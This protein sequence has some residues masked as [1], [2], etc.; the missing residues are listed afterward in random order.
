[1]R[2]PSSGAKMSET[3]QTSQLRSW[4]YA[5]WHDARKARRDN[6]KGVFLVYPMTESPVGRSKAY[7]AACLTLAGR[8]RQAHDPRN[9]KLHMRAARYHTALA[10]A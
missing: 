4:W 1:M 3:R 8:D 9:W 6:P 2:K 10:R 5:A 7:A